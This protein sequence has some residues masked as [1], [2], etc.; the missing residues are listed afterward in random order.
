MICLTSACRWRH[1][2]G[3]DV[4]NRWVVYIPKWRAAIAA[5]IVL[6]IHTPP[7]R[8]LEFIAVSIDIDVVHYGAAVSRVSQP[9]HV[10]PWNGCP[11]SPPS[12]TPKIVWH[13]IV[14]PMRCVER[15]VS[16]ILCASPSDIAV[17]NIVV[18]LLVSL[19]SWRPSC[20]RRVDLGVS[21]LRPSSSPLHTTP[22][23]WQRHV[24]TKLLSPG[25]V[26]QPLFWSCNSDASNLTRFSPLACEVVSYQPMEKHECW[27]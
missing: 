9:R 19:C 11:A 16:P 12:T 2:G 26:E 20:M 3:S 22:V 24:A 4:D 7:R 23:Q 15:D 18:V 1:Q 25:L 27:A 14:L 10:G 21:R 13:N 8:V 17:F 6:L 5:M